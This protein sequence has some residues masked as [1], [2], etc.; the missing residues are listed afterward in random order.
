M[1][2]A[3]HTMTAEEARRFIE[4]C[5]DQ[6]EAGM[7]LELARRILEANAIV[8]RDIEAERNARI[9]AARAALARRRCA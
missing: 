6:V 4:T 8:A 9:A 2:T 7:T 3:P 5:N 1:A